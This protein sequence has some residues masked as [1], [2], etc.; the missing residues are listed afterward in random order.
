MVRGILFFCIAS[1]CGCI[2]LQAQVDAK[3]VSDDLAKA[4][5][6]VVVDSVAWKLRT[7][8]GGG[9]TTVSLSNWSGG[10]QSSISVRGLILASADYANGIY[11]WDNDLDLGYGLVK[12]GGESFR[13]A[14][15]RIILTSKASIKQND[16]LR[17]TAFMDFRTQFAVGYNYDKRNP[18]DSSQFL[19]TSNLFAPAY[20]TGALG[21]EWTPVPQFKAMVSPLSSRT[22]IV[23]D[24]DLSDL[25]AYGVEPGS[26]VK[27]DVGGLL[28]VNLDWVIVENVQ[29]KS[30]LNA[31][32]R[33]NAPDLWIVTLENAILMK[34]N[35]FLNVGWMTDV[36]YDD[37]VPITR[38]NGTIGPAT[39]LRNQVV[40][41]VSWTTQNY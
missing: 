29:W 13:K 26:T 39:Q 17:Y 27:T 21:A 41:T 34:V 10:G 31:F 38:D 2:T 18:L 22:I 15:D 19:K 37:R 6:D 25:G 14:D 40:I 35:S 1:L 30:R 16:A 9:L 11:A 28:N 8:I 20:F 7:Q 12:L 4:G 5:T 32:C 24:K 33:Y 36:F 3:A 23:G